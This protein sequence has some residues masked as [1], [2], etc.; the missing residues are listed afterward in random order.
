MLEDR[1][2][3]FDFIRQAYPS[4][5]QYKIPERW[6][7]AYVENP[8]LEPG[9]LPFWIAV[10]ERGGVAGGTGALVEPLAVSGKELRVGWSVDTFLLPSFRGLGL[11]RELQ[12]L[13][14][15]ANPIFMSL[16]MSEANRRIKTSLGSVALEPVATFVKVSR[17]TPDRALDQVLSRLNLR[18]GPNRERIAGLVRALRLDRAL[19]QSLTARSARRDYRELGRIDRSLQIE[20]AAEITSEFDELWE[21]VSPRYAALI[22]RDGSYLRWKYDRQPHSRYER[23]I[24]RRGG[25][26]CGYL[27]LRLGRPPEANRGF[28]TDLF[29][30]PEDGPAIHALLAAGVA[31]L[32]AE[33]VE[34]ISA[35]TNLPAY[36]AALRRFGFRR[37]EPATPMVHCRGEAGI[38]QT[39]LARGSFLLGKGDHDWDQFPQR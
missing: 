23:L 13:N 31:R 24:A 18:E 7:W 26:P 1:D 29:A 8:Y 21:A 28:L 2:A 10:D 20:S 15:E 19:A 27:I 36:Q 30:A 34:S 14:D 3:V 9:E 17:H 37:T 25:A 39:L 4:R 33:G 22:R 12:R 38:C 32:Q 5:W 16:S 6:E 35:A 11:G